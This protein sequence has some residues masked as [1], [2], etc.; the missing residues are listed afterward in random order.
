VAGPGAAINLGR[1]S[2]II[3][4]FQAAAAG[5]GHHN[6]MGAFFAGLLC[7]GL[8][9]FFSGALPS[10]ALAGIAASLVGLA[11][12]YSRGAWAGAA[13]VSY[14]VVARS[15]ARRPW[16]GILA[17]AAVGLFAYFGPS[18]AFRERLANLF[19]DSNRIEHFRAVWKLWDGHA[20]WG[21]GSD[22]LD[23]QAKAVA[24]TLAD[25]SDEG[26]AAFAHHLHNSYLQIGLSWG[27]PALLGWLIFF[28][29]ARTRVAEAWDHPRAKVW[30]LGLVSAALAFALQA[31][32]DFLLIHARGLA[33]S[34]AWGL[35]LAAMKLAW[36]K[37]T[38]AAGI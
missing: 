28:Y 34:L 12:S 17:L 21:W 9:A 14:F 22:G 27:W 8:A 24:A 30:A 29:G 25:L 3:N 5:F 31:G 10:L 18:A 19:S 11:V 32:T 13:F 1:E 33:V 2:E 20:W 37:D 36:R 23:A 6:Q 15:P 35:M 26:R 38:L 16:V 4:G 7:L